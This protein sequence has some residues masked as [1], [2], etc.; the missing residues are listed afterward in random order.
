MTL[1]HPDCCE[2]EVGSGV[3]QFP[4]VFRVYGSNY[5]NKT[6][7]V[8]VSVDVGMTLAGQRINNSIKPMPL[9]GAA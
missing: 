4:K 2:I 1:K 5:M 6:I 9:C 8:R 3:G 7:F